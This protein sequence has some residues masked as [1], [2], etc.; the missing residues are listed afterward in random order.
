MNMARSSEF[1]FFEFYWGGNMVG[2]G[3]RELLPCENLSNRQQ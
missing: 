3:Q 2:P 1:F